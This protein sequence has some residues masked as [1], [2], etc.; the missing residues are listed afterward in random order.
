M[1]FKWIGNRNGGSKI[2]DPNVTVSS[3]TLSANS[4]AYYNSGTITASADGTAI[5]LLI[6][7]AVTTADTNI[8]A[9]RLQEGDVL[10]GDYTGTPGVTVGDFVDLEN[11]TTIDATDTT[12]GSNGKLEVLSIDTT[13]TKMKVQFIRS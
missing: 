7:V 6:P 9:I 3:L 1:A 4:L 12:E 13:N 11:S 8:T 2:V 5:Q 10:E